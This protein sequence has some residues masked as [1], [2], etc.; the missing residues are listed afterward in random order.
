MWRLVFGVPLD[1]FDTNAS[2]SNLC[3][4]P[5]IEE[6][7]Q[8]MGPAG[9]F[10]RSVATSVIL[11]DFMFKDRSEYLHVKRVWELYHGTVKMFEKKLNEA[12]MQE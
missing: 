10:H 12:R 6:L 7:D 2:T 1:T 3:R 8:A 11:N 5:E 4:K 9:F